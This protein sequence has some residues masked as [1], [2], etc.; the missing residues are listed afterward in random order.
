ML[1]KILLRREYSPLQMLMKHKKKGAGSNSIYW[2]SSVIL[3]NVY[4]GF[5]AVVPG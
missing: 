2:E 3:E 4:F 5:F 1:A